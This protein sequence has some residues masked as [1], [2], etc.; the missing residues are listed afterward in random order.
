[1]DLMIKPGE[2]IDIS[3]Q[4]RDYPYTKITFQEFD[5]DSNYVYLKFNTNMPYRVGYDDNDN[6]TFIDPSGGPMINVGSYTIKDLVIEE[7]KFVENNET[8]V[9]L[10]KK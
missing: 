2:I 6:I 10:K 8:H 3:Y 9:K 4:S 1:M 5:T 7:I